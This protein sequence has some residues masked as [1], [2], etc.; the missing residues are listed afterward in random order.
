MK[1]LKSF[2]NGDITTG[3]DEKNLEVGYPRLADCGGFELM[4]CQPNSRQL[5]V[6]DYTLAAKGL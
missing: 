5:A 6:L 1:F 4:V 3:D 2:P